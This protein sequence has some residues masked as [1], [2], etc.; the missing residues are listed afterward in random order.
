MHKILVIQRGLGIERA[1]VD[2][3][4]CAADE[5]ALSRVHIS[6]DVGFVKDQEQFSKAGFQKVSN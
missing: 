1:L 3:V 2:F 6:G 4:I 5:L